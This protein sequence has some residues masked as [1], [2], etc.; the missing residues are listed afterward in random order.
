MLGSSNSSAPPNGIMKPD[1]DKDATHILDGP[2]YP[3]DI[4]TP[5]RVSNSLF[6]ISNLNE[7]H[8]YPLKAHR[9]ACTPW[10][11]D[12]VTLCLLSGKF[13]NHKNKGIFGRIELS[14][15]SATTLK[16]P[17][18]CGSTWFS[19]YWSLLLMSFFCPDGSSGISVNQAFSLSCW[20]R[21]E[22]RE[23][24]PMLYCAP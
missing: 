6:P 21:L 19:H 20:I 5:G 18:L 24:K 12:M 2:Y 7:S 16:P 10:P 15:W 13:Q 14:H 1:K 9:R 23:C 4:I 22:S 11:E 8:P 3:T 17:A